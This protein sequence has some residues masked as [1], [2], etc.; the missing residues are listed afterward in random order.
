M[1]KFRDIDQ[2][3]FIVKE[4]TGLDIMYAYDDL[5]FP[6]HGVFIIRF[7]DELHDSVFCHFNEDCIKTEKERF[8]TSLSDVAE[9][10]HLK[11]ELGAS[12]SLSEKNNKEVELK[13]LQI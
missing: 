1:V 4:A 11:M 10:N 2:I 5:V 12:Y 9:L 3:T 13:F 6:E 7:N 8:F